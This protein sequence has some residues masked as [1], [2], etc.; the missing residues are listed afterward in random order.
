[1]AGRSTYEAPGAPDSC[2][3]KKH[4]ALPRSQHEPPPKLATPSTP[5]RR[6]WRTAASTAVVGTWERT[7]A[8]VDATARPSVRTSRAPSSEASRPSVETSSQRRAPVARST[9]G[10]RDDAPAP[11]TI[12]CAKPVW[13]QAVGAIGRDAT[14]RRPGLLPEDGVLVALDRDGHAPADVPLDAER[15]GERLLADLAGVRPHR[16]PLAVHVG[17]H[18]DPGGDPLGG[19]A[20]LHLVH[21]GRVDGAELGR[22]LPRRG[23]QR[24]EVVPVHGA[25]EHPWRARQLGGPNADPVDLHVV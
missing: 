22:R 19:H 15:P 16:R 7:W 24:P 1:M 5:S 8:K 23:H 13:I 3:R 11:N 4:T 2:S 21:V 17:G 9:S 25:L 18:V 20:Q 14:S 12:R 10:S 6:A